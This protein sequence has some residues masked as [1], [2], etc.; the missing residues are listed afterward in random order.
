M[1]QSVNI[2][3]QSI[4]KAISKVI[5]WKDTSIVTT[6]ITIIITIAIMGPIIVYSIIT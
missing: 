1:A 4:G 3:Y 6:I 2:I 5:R